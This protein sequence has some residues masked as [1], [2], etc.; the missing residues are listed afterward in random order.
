LKFAGTAGVDRV[1]SNQAIVDGANVAYVELSPEG[2]PK[3]SNLVAVCEL[4]E[5]GGYETTVIVDASLRHEVD[6]PKQLEAIFDGR[7]L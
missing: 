5:A 6:D 4:L 2:D 3:V 7:R 1:S